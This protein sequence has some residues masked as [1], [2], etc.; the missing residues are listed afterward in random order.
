[1]FRVYD[2]GLSENASNSL[3]KI[4]NSLETINFGDITFSSN[5]EAFASE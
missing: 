3:H 2:S 1:M 5:S 4:L